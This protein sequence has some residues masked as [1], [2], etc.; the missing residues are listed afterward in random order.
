M[1]YFH[2]DPAT[3]APSRVTENTSDGNRAATSRHD[4]KTFGDA[5]ALAEEYNAALGATPGWRTLAPTDE[6][7]GVWPRHDVIR[8]PVVGDR[9]SRTFNGDYYPAGVVVR[10]SDSFRRVA[11]DVGVV[12]YRRGLS[13]SWVSD[14]TWSMAAGW[15]DE[16]NPSF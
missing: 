10:V 15:R 16:K 11:T 2:R 6:G 12:F 7:A 8:A 9:V 3:G 14:G 5:A 4:L 1:L 13:S